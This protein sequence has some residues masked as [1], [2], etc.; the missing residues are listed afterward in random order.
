MKRFLLKLYWR[1][2]R[3]KFARS[4]RQIVALNVSFEDMMRSMEVPE[5]EKELFRVIYDNYPRKKP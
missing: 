2:M 1:L 3:R 5:E 4:M